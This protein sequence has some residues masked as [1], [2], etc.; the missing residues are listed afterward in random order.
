M[1]KTIETTVY[2]FDELTDKAKQ[3]AVNDHY[4]NV[5]YPWSAEALKSLSALAEHFGG[6]MTDYSIDWTGCCSHSWAK[7]DMP[8]A[9][10]IGNNNLPDHIHRAIGTSDATEEDVKAAYDKWLSD[11]LA[12]LG[13][14][15]PQTLKGH[16]DC[17][18]TG[19]CM[20]ESAID[21][22]RAA[23]VAGETD[24]EK[25]MQ[26]AFETWHSDGVDDFNGMQ[27]FDEFSETADANEY[28]FHSNGKLA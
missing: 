18:L 10:D 23:F 9:E 17:K 19:F 13:T 16:G 2:Q 26:A 5:G 8:D 4:D 27:E 14:Y 21:G 12:A 6:K 3:R 20:D 25:L 24:L 11:K 15:D 28:W 22:F 7:F 1:P